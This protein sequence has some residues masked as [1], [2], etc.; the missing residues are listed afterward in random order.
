MSKKSC[1]K[2]KCT[3]FSWNTAIS[4]KL[5]LF[6]SSLAFCHI[7]FN[8]NQIFH[9]TRCIAPKSVTSWWGPSSRH[10][11]Q[12]NTASYEEM[13]QRWWAVGNIVSN[14][15]G[16]R[17][18]LQTSRSRNE[19]DLLRFET[20]EAKFCNNKLTYC[21]D[22][23]GYCGLIYSILLCFYSVKKLIQLMR[24]KFFLL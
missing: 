17:F 11:A 19:R 24:L 22:N 14:L 13:L 21:L 20:F 23:N 2:T 15:T 10:S 12:T 16:P 6:T 8:S 1:R 18:K 5:L 9:Y 3:N 7:A 4:C